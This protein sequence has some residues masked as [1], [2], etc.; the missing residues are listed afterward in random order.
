MIST[1]NRL[2]VVLISIV[3]LYGCSKNNEPNP[4]ND[5]NLSSS[6]S[7][8]D[9][10]ID[11][12]YERLEKHIQDN[13]KI[14][15]INVKGIKNISNAKN[16]PSEFSYLVN[17]YLSKISDKTKFVVC[18]LCKSTRQIVVNGN[19]IIWKP[20]QL[21]G[22]LT[23]FDS[24]RSVSDTWRILGLIGKGTGE[25][26]IDY[27][28]GSET[29]KLTAGLTLSLLNEKGF[30]LSKASV[31]N[32]IDVIKKTNKNKFSFVVYGNG[33]NI[34]GSINE[35][36]GIQSAVQILVAYSVFQ[37][38]SEYTGFDWKRVIEE[39]RLSLENS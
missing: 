33:I 23:T 26:D 37:L 34:N 29:E 3:F 5:L 14:Y 27:T 18:R 11:A 4:E 24:T 19:P 12:A 10:I 22:A 36:Y 13:T 9:K 7:F 38:V 16:L 32:Q 21:I 31:S 15:F 17:H 25:T 1:A 2:I 35:K 30:Q 20:N 39:T 8:D 6:Y 28:R